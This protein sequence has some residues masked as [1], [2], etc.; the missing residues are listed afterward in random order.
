MN[1]RDYTKAK[2]RD[3]SSRTLV[4]RES[5]IRTAEKRLACI[6]DRE[7]FSVLV[8]ALVREYYSDHSLYSRHTEET[9]DLY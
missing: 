2:C 1:V 7:L 4:L 6:E 5:A 3:D 9:N 8:R